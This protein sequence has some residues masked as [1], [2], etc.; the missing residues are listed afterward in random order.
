MYQGV[1]LT[2]IQRQRRGIIEPTPEGVGKKTKKS[3]PQRGGIFFGLVQRDFIR[4]A[5]PDS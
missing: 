4:A 2:T 1:S 3:K 5:Q